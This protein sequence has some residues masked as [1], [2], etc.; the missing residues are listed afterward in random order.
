MDYKAE[1]EYLRHSLKVSNKIIEEYQQ[2]IIP[3]FREIIEKV[4]AQ[5]DAMKNYIRSNFGWCAGCKHFK[6]MF[7]CGSIG[8]SNCH[9]SNDHYEFDY[10]EE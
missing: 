4:E 10:S 1:C 3:G 5:R 9:D 7:G 2:E 6:G 8:M